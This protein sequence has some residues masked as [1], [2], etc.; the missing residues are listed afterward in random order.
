MVIIVF[1]GCLWFDRTDFLPVPMDKRYEQLKKQ[2]WKQAPKIETKYN[3]SVK[4]NRYLLLK[5]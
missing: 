5:T 1:D 2:V 4:Y 3:F